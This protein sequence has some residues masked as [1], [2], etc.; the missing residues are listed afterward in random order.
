LTT[1]QVKLVEDNIALA[2]HLALAAMQRGIQEQDFDDVVAVAFEGLSLAAANFDPSRANVVD[3]KPD[4]AKAFS[5][6]ARLRINGAIVDWQRRQDNVPRLKRAVYQKLEANGDLG[7]T[8]EELADLTGMAPRVIQLLVFH[9]HRMSRPVMLSG[10]ED[11]DGPVLSDV[12]DDVFAKR[13]LDA[14]GDAFDALDHLQRVI[15]SMRYYE[16][17]SFRNIAAEVGV[18]RYAVSANHQAAVEIIHA[19]MLREALEQAYHEHG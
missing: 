18:S 11:L 19:A 3:G 4:V 5:G 9:V 6:Y 2:K 17:K 14:F 8:P 1:A 15:I 16:G 12:S 7:R 13:L 10:I